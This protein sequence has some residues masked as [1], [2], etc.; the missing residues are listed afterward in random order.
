MVQLVPLLHDNSFIDTEIETN[1]AM[2]HSWQSEWL[3]SVFFRKKKSRDKVPTGTTEETD[4]VVAR[5]G[6]SHSG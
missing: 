2:H 4:V 6:P 1:K 3:I 5:G